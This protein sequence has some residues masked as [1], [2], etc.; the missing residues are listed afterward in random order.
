[1]Q[2]EVADEFDRIHSIGRAKEVGSADAII[3]PGELRPY[4][5]ASVARGMRRAE[6]AG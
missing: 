2:A 3:S 6:I 5:I 4:L 1:M